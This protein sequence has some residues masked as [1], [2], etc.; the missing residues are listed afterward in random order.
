MAGGA[1]LALT[2]AESSSSVAAMQPPAALILE[3][4]LERAGAQVRRLEQELALVVSDED[5]TQQANGQAIAPRGDR[6]PGQNS[7]PQGRDVRQTAA[8]RRTRA[9]VLFLWLPDDAVWLT[10]RNVRSVDGRPV[11]GSDM[12]LSDALS[13]GPGD[14]VLRLRRLV[15]E[16]ARFNVGRTFRNFNYPT[17][18]LSY[19]DPAVQ[20]RF[21]F[22]LAGRERVNDIAVSKVTYDERSTPTVIRGDGRDL[23]SRGAMWITDDGAVARTTLELT[24]AGDEAMSTAAIDV[25]YRHD[26][27]LAV[28][29]PVRM[30]ERY[31]ETHGATVTE[32]IAGDATY[33][34]FRHVET[35]GRLVEPR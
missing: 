9:D 31:V 17:Q 27:A 7:A 8:R 23:R 2:M 21:V 32:R 24:I 5:Y 26:P 34:N 28:W 20:S 3:R 15:D 11:A 25:R 14:R 13:A 22:K 12:R 10:V 35:A 6:Y 16:S 33:S 30:Q 1:L 19:L 4:L 29:L 18:V